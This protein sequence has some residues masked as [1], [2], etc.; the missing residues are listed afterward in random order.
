MNKKA[1]F[2][3]IISLFLISSIIFS[4]I[5][6]AE[7]RSYSIPSTNID[8]YLQENGN[9]HV[10]ETI[11]YSFSGTYNGVYR[12][13]PLK[14]NEK[15]ENIQIHVNKA[16][17]TSKIIST[18]GE[19]SI[20]L[21]LY[22]DP[23]KTIPISNKDVDVIIEYDFL[24]VITFYDDVA[25]LHYKLW[26]EKWEIPAGRVNAN[27]HLKSKDNVKYEINPS[28]LIEN[29]V[30]EN[31]TL[32]ITSKNIPSG[33]WFE[34]RMV[35]PK[36][37]FVSYI[38]NLNLKTYFNVLISILMLLSLI[39]P[40]QIYYKNL[41]PKNR[42][43]DG[44]TFEMPK[45]ELPAVINV[46]FGSEISKP[47]GG[48]D[49]NGFI[50]TIMDLVNRGY[51]FLDSNQKSTE[52]E[53][54]QL[55]LQINHMKSRGGLKTCEIDALEFLSKF[56][57]NGT[58]SLKKLKKANKKNPQ[59]FDKAYCRWRK[60]LM[61]RLLKPGAMDKILKIRNTNGL[62]IYGVLGS[63]MAVLFAFAN[64][65]SPL[66]SAIYLLC[67]SIILGTVSFV[68]LIMSQKLKVQW[69]D[70]GIQYKKQW[71]DFKKYIKNPKLVKENPPDSTKILDK[72]LIYATALGIQDK[73]LKSLQY[74]FNNE[75][76]EKS[77]IYIFHAFG[78]CLALQL[79]LKSVLSPSIAAGTYYAGSGR[80]GGGGS[81]GF[82]GGGAGG[83]GAGGGS[84]GGGGGA[85]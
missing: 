85:F 25:V 29:E 67:A 65:E 72:Y 64:L 31:Q 69:T 36:D 79:T 15:I 4:N 61:G 74:S 28:Y 11:H 32:H 9:L 24:H 6:Y 27:I 68:S 12:D 41:K 46:L 78:G 53:E 52:S 51:L 50:A 70:Y 14:S 38:D 47:I 55:I 26:G 33:Q 63:I 82:G 30:W 42:N 56:G 13:I 1:H 57:N 73:A 80:L 62:Y 2:I 17:Y 83:G 22:S 71:D 19:K 48:P 21:Y 37:Q 3:C 77:S 16:Y 39:Y 7:D 44:K 5:S 43:F 76:L 10:K 75:E 84:G 34:L 23:A 40:I 81:G 60:H 59:L 18:D 45:N 8:L 58:I 35:I 66:P 54:S 49:I 20:T